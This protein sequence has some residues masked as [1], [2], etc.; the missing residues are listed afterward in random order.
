MAFDAAGF[1]LV[2]T[3]ADNSGS[4]VDRTYNYVPDMVYADILTGIAATIATIAATTDDLITGYTIQ[5]V[6]N[7][8]TIVLPAAGVQS[9]NQAIITTPLLGKPRDSG[10]LTIPAAK[11]GVF[12]NTS[13]P[14]A[15]VVNTAASIV[16]NFVGLFVDGGIFTLSDG[17]LAIIAGMKGKRRHTKNNNG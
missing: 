9:E 15:N 13:G 7:N 17:D 1:K 8:D 11:I 16:T 12:V 2:V 3:F 10:T 6:F 5:T 4:K 14:G